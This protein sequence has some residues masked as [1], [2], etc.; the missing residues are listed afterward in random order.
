MQ[1]IQSILFCKLDSKIWWFISTLLY[2]WLQSSDDL[3]QPYFTVDFSQ[4]GLQDYTV[5]IRSPSGNIVDFS[6]TSSYSDLRKEILYVPMEAGQHEIYINYCGFELPGRLCL[7]IQRLGMFYRNRVGDGKVK[8][9]I[10][11]IPL[12]LY[13]IIFCPFGL[14]NDWNDKVIQLWWDYMQESLII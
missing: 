6:S 5:V 13:V 8:F 12:I 11:P 14:F 9:Q 1:V 4:V 3:F 10:F 7:I 2:S